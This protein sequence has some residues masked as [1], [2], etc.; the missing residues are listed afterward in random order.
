MA[1]DA[2]GH[3]CGPTEKG[4]GKQYK[5]GERDE[6]ELDNCNEDLDRQYE[7]GDDHDDPCQEQDQDL[8]K[9]GEK[10]YRPDKIGRC[11]EKWL[12]RTKSSCCHTTRPHEIADSHAAA[13]G[14]EAKPCKTFE[15][16][17]GKARK[18]ANDIC[19]CT[20]VERLLDQALKYILIGTPSPEQGRNSH[21]DHDKRR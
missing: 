11:I 9:I 5:T 20:D 7:E 10:S 4:E 21:V 3:E 13:A 14:L 6:L 8:H 2:L 1:K 16:D 17:S 12:G 19:E 15:H 18:I